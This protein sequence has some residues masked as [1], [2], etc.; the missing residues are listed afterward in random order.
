MG[1]VGLRIH[2]HTISL[3]RGCH[4]DRGRCGVSPFPQTARH[5]AESALTSSQAVEVAAGAL[6]KEVEGFLSRVAA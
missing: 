1:V 4:F 2:R 3:R 6:R 5:S